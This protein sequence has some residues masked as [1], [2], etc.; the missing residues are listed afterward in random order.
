MPTQDLRF[1]SA[2]VLLLAQAQDQHFPLVL[3]NSINP[4]LV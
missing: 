2:L 4:V 1:L 3:C